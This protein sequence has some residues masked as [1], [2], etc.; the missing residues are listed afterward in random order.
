MI[1]PFFSTAQRQ[2]DLVAAIKPWL[3]TPYLDGCGPKAK[4]G[5][6]ADCTWVAGPLQQLGAVG[7]VPW[8]QRYVA[9][10]GGAK[11]LEVLLHV[12]D[13]VERLN[14]IWSRVSGK[15]APVFIPGDVL[16]YSAGSR[17][18]HLCLYLGANR[19]VHSWFGKV[20]IGNAKDQRDRLLRAVYRAY[21]YSAED[22]ALRTPH[23]ALL[24]GK[25]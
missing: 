5:A 15:K 4:P 23:S 21:S 3:G 16:V 6:C 24:H 18:H 25:P 17:M 19:T 11:M 8:P 13:G 2:A 1:T 9:R 12:L 20:Q 10:G 22:P 7:A 14:C